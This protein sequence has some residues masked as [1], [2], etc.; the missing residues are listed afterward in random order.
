[1]TKLRVTGMTCGHCENAVKKALGAVPG[2]DRVVDV[3]RERNEAIV[4]GS[5]DTA[6]LVAAVKEEGYEAEALS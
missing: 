6:A 1:M 4:E 3:S 5:A 2:V